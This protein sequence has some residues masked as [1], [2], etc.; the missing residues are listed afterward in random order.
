MEPEGPLLHSQAPASSPY[1]EP[2][3]PTAC[4]PRPTS[5]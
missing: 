1:P 4:P 3:Q 5:F 2:A